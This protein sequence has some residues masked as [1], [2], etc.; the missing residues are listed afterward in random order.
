MHGFDHAGMGLGGF[1]MILLWLVPF[2]LVVWLFARMQSNGNAPA[3]PTPL[4]VLDGR[5]ARGEI[6][7]DEYRLRRADLLGTD[8]KQG[9]RK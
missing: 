9:E 8:A 4:D 3:T 6:E 5:Y 1:G 2:V 7:Q